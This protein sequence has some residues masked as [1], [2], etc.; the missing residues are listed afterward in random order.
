MF[1]EYEQCVPIN[2]QCLKFNGLLVALLHHKELSI[3]RRPI[4]DALSGLGPSAESR[5]LRL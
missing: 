4:E 3:E 1:H 5:A 2:W